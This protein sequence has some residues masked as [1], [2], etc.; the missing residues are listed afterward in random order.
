[1]RKKPSQ[2]PL[3]RLSRNFSA[4]FAITLSS[5]PKAFRL[6]KGSKSSRGSAIVMACVFMVLAVSL[7]STAA[8]LVKTARNDANQESYS[9]AL[10]E[11]AAQAGLED[12]IGWFKRQPSQPVAANPTYGSP[13]PTPTFPVTYQGMPVSYNDEVFY[14]IYN[15][16]NP[17]TTDTIDSTG[18]IGLVNE[19]SPYGAGSVSQATTNGDQPIWERYEVQRQLPTPV[20][21]AVHDAT[22]ERVYNFK[23]G[24]GLVWTISCTGYAYKR[25]DFTKS[26]TAPYYWTVP[27]NV[28]P[29]KVLATARMATE[30]RKM[31][32][33]MPWGDNAAL[34]MYDISKLNVQTNTMVSNEKQA[35]STAWVS[36]L[37]GNPT[38]TGANEI[39]GGGVTTLST[40]LNLSCNDVFGMSVTD[41]QNIADNI[42]NSTTQ[43]LNFSTLA[44]FQL[45]YFNGN[46]TIDPA[47]ANPNYYVIGAG[48]I[49]TG[50]LI[51]NGN[52]TM[53]S[54]AATINSYYGLVWVA[55][56][57]NLS[58]SSI[59]GALIL[60]NSAASEGC[61]LAPNA[62]GYQATINY[63]PKILANLQTTVAQ[64]REDIS[65][66]K[67]F[68]A[69]PGF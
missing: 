40:A 56:T 7:M 32:L 57:V 17:A 60:G 58:G 63:N 33:N 8:Q 23:D 36:Y 3:E 22:G 31:S 62:A 43:P 42:G 15:T 47:G 69:I 14:P 12:A 52:F 13:N 21:N 28:Y 26:A 25:R 53:N 64:Y 51:V 39:Q 35:S 37:A 55:G 20:S 50:V 44:N 67:K 29:N 4:F 68:L 5:R 19:F 18:Q 59:N 66:R 10:A 46:L 11:N 45:T 61:T 30:V 6:W 38:T 41:I 1:M 65:A 27:Y 48:G 34:Y 2:N 49:Q 9:V 24:Q 16:S 54:S